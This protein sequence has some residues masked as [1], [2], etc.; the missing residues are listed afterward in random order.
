MNVESFERIE[1]NRIKNMQVRLNIEYKFDVWLKIRCTLCDRIRENAVAA[2]TMH[3]GRISPYLIPQR[4]ETRLRT[5]M[6]ARTGSNKSEQE[7]CRGILYIY[8]R[9]IS[10]H[11]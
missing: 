3:S 7:S 4:D 5:G 8:M 11:R 1:T 9:S 10:Y 2:H 6:R